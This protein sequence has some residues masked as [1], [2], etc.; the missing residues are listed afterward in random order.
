MKKILLP[1]LAISLSI[2]SFAQLKNLKG[3]GQVFWEETFDWAD[4]DN[5][6][7]WSLPEGWIIEDNSVD[8]SGYVWVWTQDSMQ[9]PTSKRDGG[10]I[11]NSTS[12]DNGFLAIDLDSYNSVYYPNYGEMLTVNSTI[13]LPVLDC[14]DHPSVIISMEQMFKYFGSHRMVIEVSNDA[15]AHWG[16][17]DLT[18]GTGSSVNTLN[19]PN[20]GVAHY[21]ANLS[22][23]AGGQAEVIIKITWEGSLLYF[24]M[25]DD[26]TIREGWDNDLKMNHWDV[27]LVDENS[28]D[29]QGFY[30][31][32]PKTQILPI[33]G[34]EGSVINNGENAQS[35]VYF[36]VEIN[37]NG[38][39]QF[40]AGSESVRYLFFGDPADTL[41]IEETYTPVDY[42]HYDITFSMIADEDEQFP[43]NNVKSYFF[44]VTD[45]V[46][47][48]TP[49]EKEANESPWR[50]YYT[51]THE[52][53]YMGV[54]YDPISD[55]EASSISVY[56]ARANLNAD[57]KFVLLEIEDGEGS[58]VNVIELISTETWRVEQSMLDEGWVTLPLEP[59]GYGEFMKAG[60]RYIAAVQFWTYIEEENLINRADAFW[61]GSTRNYP[62]SYDKQWLYES[63]SQTW[64]QGSDFNKMIRLNINNHENIID[65]ISNLNNLNSLAQN[66]PNP[67]NEFTQIDYELAK[68]EKVSIEITDLT[69][70]IIMILD[71]GFRTAGKYSASL[72]SQN[73]EAG[74][75]Y[76]TLKVG[77]SRITKKMLVSK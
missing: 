53:D 77:E 9:G 61:I 69:G 6:R 41:T 16:E 43:E 46:F 25:L 24:W 75:Y 60:N 49:D 58:E 44:H 45:S 56:I 35:H 73:I 39:E 48:R 74:L 65:G 5:P 4:P 14:S 71:E 12:A 57:F 59:D 20:D 32:M 76:Y 18:M 54:E 13:T 55:C 7:G 29:S 62:D 67:F 27:S 63:N 3:D 64:T 15:G 70:R 1:L 42:G 37:K 38:V 21:T 72:K 26:I 47:A 52:G 23:V 22:D 11:L 66:Y 8:D 28:N 36:D 40:K 34:L 19:L 30:Y 68:A 51:Y 2:S 33:A 17:F 10:Y 31:M 50:D